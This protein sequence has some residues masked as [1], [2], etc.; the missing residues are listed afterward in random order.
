MGTIA[1]R[2]ALRVLELTE[3]VAAGCLAAG[4]QAAELRLRMGE[5]PG[6]LRDTEPGRMLASIRELCPFVS[7]DRPLERDLRDL[8]AAIRRREWRLYE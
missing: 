3:Q 5:L 4:A 7:E 1:A 2:D 8:V 6:S